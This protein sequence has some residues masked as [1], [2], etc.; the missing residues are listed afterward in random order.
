MG[1]WLNANGNN[2]YGDNVEKILGLIQGIWNGE[3]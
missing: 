1:W 2:A 3:V